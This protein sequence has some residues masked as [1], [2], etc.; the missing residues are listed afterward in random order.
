ML[1]VFNNNQFLV[2]V[3]KDENNEPLF[4]LNDACKS[5][6]LTNT[7]HAKKSIE[8]EW[9]GVTLNVTPFK[10]EGG[11]QN[12][13]MISEPQLYF[14]IMRSDKPNA[15]AFRM[16]VN[17]EVLPTIRKQGYY[18]LQKETDNKISNLERRNKRVALGYKS[19]L[20]QQKEK[21]ELKLKVLE[22]ELE[23]KSKIDLDNPSNELKK[24]LA[25]RGWLLMNKDNFN[26][27]GEN[28]ATRICTGLRD[29]LG[30]NY[31]PCLKQLI[32]ISFMEARN[33]F[34]R[35]IHLNQNKPYT[36]ESYKIK[37]ADNSYTPIYGKWII[38]DGK[39][40]AGWELELRWKGDK[41]LSYGS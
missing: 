34:I 40:I 25:E 1:E 38:E 7:N 41:K 20:A 19:Q 10:T 18:K 5:L 6:E 32:D 23:H 12:F 3:A 33:Y 16:W 36:L 15:K 27:L 31:P 17:C 35:K 26:V 21:Y 29:I 4:C 14:L 39:Q 30:T 9:Q 2:R 13:T 22:C 11:V 28:I 8:R 24:A 37:R